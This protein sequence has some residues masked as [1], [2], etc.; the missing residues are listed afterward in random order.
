MITILFFSV[1]LPSVAAV[2]MQ[3]YH[4]QPAS[5]KMQANTFGNVVGIGGNQQINDFSGTLNYDYPLYLPAGRNALTPQVG[6]S[7]NS[8]NHSSD[9]ILGVGWDLSLPKIARFSRQ[10]TVHLYDGFNFTSPL[11]GGSGELFSEGVDSN[12]RGNY[13]PKITDSQ[14]KHTL[15]NDNSWQ[16]IDAGGKQYY[17]GQTENSREQS[18]DGLKIYAWYLSKIVDTNGN[19]INYQYTKNQGLVYLQKIIYGDEAKPFEILFKPFVNGGFDDNEQYSTKILPQFS[20]GFAQGRNKYLLTEI[21][22]KDNIGGEK[23]VYDLNYQ[24][25][26]GKYF[27]DNIVQEGIKVDGSREEMLP[28]ALY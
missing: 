14:V 12:G 3:P 24:E 18:E 27:L 23:T 19:E 16:V 17:F 11:A 22:V 20:K 4:H 6:L 1:L 13:L 15:Q 2:E 9:G 7:Y 28:T 8:A 10:G 5:I 26:A 21:E 25:E